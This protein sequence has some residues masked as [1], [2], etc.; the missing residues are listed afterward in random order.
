MKFESISLAI[1]LLENGH[2]IAIP[3]DTV[4]GLVCLP[5][6]LDAIDKI[7]ELKGRPK[8]KKL[9]T[10]TLTPPAIP[11]SLQPFAD[12]HWPGPLTLI[13]NGEG[14]RIPNHPITLAILEQV[15]PLV[16][17]SVNRSGEKAARIADE[18]TLPVPILIGG[19]LPSGIPSTIIS[20][21]GVLRSSS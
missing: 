15:G 18:I 4:Y 3:T 16:S 2:V 13:I 8:E 10:L 7:Y 5:K 21:S 12:K 6:F 17:T 20:E 11:P 1:N 14:Y 9:I 19:P